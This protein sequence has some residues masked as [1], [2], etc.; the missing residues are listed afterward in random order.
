M[1][2][3]STEVAKVALLLDDKAF[4]K[5]FKADWHKACTDNHIDDGLI[6]EGLGS[7]LASLAHNEWQ[8]VRKVKKNLD[9]YGT[10]EHA[11]AQMV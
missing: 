4:R 2:D 5:A 9:K 7:A 3:I 8:V 11:A 6:P 1:S 10:S